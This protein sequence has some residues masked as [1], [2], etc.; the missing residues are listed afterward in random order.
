MLTGVRSRITFNQSI[1]C[2]VE[3]EIVSKLSPKLELFAA[4]AEVAKGAANPHRL[5]L[6]EHASQGERTVEEL[7]AVSGL[8]VAN[9][10][11]HLLRLRRSG[12]V[13]SRREGKRVLYSLSGRQVLDL[14]AA[15]RVIGERHVADAQRTIAQF[16]AE[17]DAMEPLSASALARGLKAGTILLLDVRPGNEFALGHLRGAVNIPLGHLARRL[18][19][20]PRSKQ[21]VAYC[22]GPYCVL[23]FEAVAMLRGKGFS[24]RRLEGGFPECSAA[25]L[26]T[27][28]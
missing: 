4:F 1:E 13:A 28:P 16:F 24:A 7:A 18:K 3:G 19:G 21:I 9:A 15:L 20:L 2:I 27:D 14:L 10:S 8:S 17:R 12:L 26:P 22:R 5:D 11:Q 23:A 25:G 6:L